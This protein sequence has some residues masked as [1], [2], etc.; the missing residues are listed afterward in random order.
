MP[1]EEGRSVR[2]TLE[3]VAAR[4]RSSHAGERS[5]AR[6]R[7]L[8]LCR[9]YRIDPAEYGVRIPAPAERV[10]QPGAENPS[11]GYA[12]RCDELADELERIAPSAPQPREVLR[13][14]RWLRFEAARWRAHARDP[15]NFSLGGNARGC[16]TT[17][18]GFDDIEHRDYCRSP[19][20]PQTARAA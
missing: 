3:G 15:F 4:L 13:D 10:E 18:A 19:V 17:I 12:H 7:L 9:K 5:A 14:V 1:R 2:R 11:W 6:D 16:A 20:C 8:Y